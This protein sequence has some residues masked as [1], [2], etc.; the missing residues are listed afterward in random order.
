MLQSDTELCTESMSEEEDCD[1]ILIG[2]VDVESENYDDDNLEKN[3][4]TKETRNLLR[5]KKLLEKAHQKKER[6]EQQV[7]VSNFYLF[8]LLYTT[9]S[10]C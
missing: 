3:S 7:N 10:I 2:E 5:Q 1:A 8:T 4:P 6:Y 9:V